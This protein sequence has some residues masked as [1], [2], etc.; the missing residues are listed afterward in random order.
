MVSGS[1][2]PAAP[3]PPVPPEAIAPEVFQAREGAALEVVNQSFSDL[4]RHL[5]ECFGPGGWSNRWAH[6]RSQRPGWGQ[7]EQNYVVTAGNRHQ[8]INQA[9]AWFRDWNSAGQPA[10]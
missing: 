6:E 2:E 5:P 8:T 7:R 3:A 4:I 1:P 9:W 10:L